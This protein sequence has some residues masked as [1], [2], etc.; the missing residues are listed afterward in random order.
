MME[1]FFVHVCELREYL[2]WQARVQGGQRILLDQSEEQE[3][4]RVAFQ[5]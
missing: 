2:P 4:Q 1:H 5:D 3:P